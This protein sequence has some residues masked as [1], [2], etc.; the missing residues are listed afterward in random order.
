M[1]D[2]LIIFLSD[3]GTTRLLY[4]EVGKQPEGDKPLQYQSWCVILIQTHHIFKFG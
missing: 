4:T 3:N 2:T 1:E